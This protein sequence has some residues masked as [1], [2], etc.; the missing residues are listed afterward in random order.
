MLGS[1][2]LIPSVR[3]E[4]SDSWH[5]Y[6]EMF[7]SEQAAGASSSLGNVQTHGLWPMAC[8]NLFG[9]KVDMRCKGQYGSNYLFGL[10]FPEVGM[11]RIICLALGW[12]FV[13]KDAWGSAL[14]LHSL[15]ARLCQSRL[16]LPL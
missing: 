2:D 3:K 1:S 5:A 16:L 6:L 9:Q 7:E 10:F 15:F 12:F 14:L 8:L 4:V 13:P 11:V